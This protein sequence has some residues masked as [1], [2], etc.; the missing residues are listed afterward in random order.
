MTVTV[1][2]SD[3]S[4][5]WVVG[6]SPTV[7]VVWAITGL[8]AASALLLT[9]TSVVV[10]AG[11]VF[12]VVLGVLLPGFV[13]VRAVRPAQAALVSDLAWAAPVGSFVPFAAWGVGAATHVSVP[14]VLAGPVVAAVLLALPRCRPRIL[15]RSGHGWDL[16]TTVGVSGALL[17][18]TG[19]MTVDY[20][21]VVPPMPE[22]G[23]SSYY[24]DAVFQLAVV[25]HLQHSPVL[26]YPL[27]AGEP[28]SYQWFTHAVLAPLIG[29]G[30][31]GFDTMLRLVPVSVLLA[32]VVLL[33]VVAGDLAQ[34]PVAAVAAAALATVV[35]TSVVTARPDGDSIA[36]FQTYWWAS[37]TT[38]FGWLVTIAVAGIVLDLLRADRAP[39]TSAPV[40]LFVPMTLLSVGTKPSN[41]VGLVAGAAAVV[42]IG[43]LYRTT[44]TRSAGVLVVL[45][46]S[47]IAARLTIYGGGDYGLRFDPFGG[48]VKRAARLFPG[49][50]DPA[51]DAAGT[52]SLPTVST[53]ALVAGALMFLLPLLPRLIGL[54]FLDRRDPRSWFFWFASAAALLAA[55]LF[56]H[57]AESELF[58]LLSAYP[59]LLLGSAW[60]IAS[61]WT[62]PAAGRGRGPAIA[63]GIAAGFA[64]SV[65][66]AWWFPA[67]PAD[68]RAAAFGRPPDALEMA[69][70]LQA[71]QS[72]A[73]LLV[74]VLIAAGVLVLARLA[75]RARLMAIGVVGGLLGTGLLSTALYLTGSPDAASRVSIADRRSVVTSD[76]VIA[77]TWLAENTRP[78][79]V[80]ATNRVCLGDQEGA[81]LPD[82]CISK[83]FALSAT[84]RRDLL[85][86]GWAYAS[87]NLGTAWEATGPI[88]A[89]QPFWEPSLLEMEL[90]AFRTPTPAAITAVRAAGAS[91]MVMD[92]RGAPV[93]E[94]GLDRIADRRFSTSTVV[95]WELR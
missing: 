90:A 70:W 75:G 88:W 89:A 35:G 32:T 82:P 68:A 37:L 81:V 69:P 48:F 38:S 29:V 14:G 9:G 94:A 5:Q 39:A 26:T 8:L 57:P 7:G 28:F 55:S 47:L 61:W 76:E 60:G 92:R 6:R 23:G 93:D 18:A 34:R 19:W 78:D 72:L 42:V 11:W 36:V 50:V 43:F 20:L 49:L 73:P 1:S 91:W 15:R 85:V 84:A 95:V 31:S 46:G 71:V 2:R 3:R 10:L 51:P 22:P 54:V 12:T 52:M 66:L 33:A 63:I 45:A 53:I 4:A 67:N 65:V 83:T 41:L 21:S 27:V 40:A 13:L 80:L 74:V 25:G 17:V 79:D 16:R 87:R 30:P 44:V 58:F 64:T 77:G 59:V 86:G 56:R 62:G 24:P